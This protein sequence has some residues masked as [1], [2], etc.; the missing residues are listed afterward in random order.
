MVIALFKVKIAILLDPNNSWI[1]PYIKTISLNTDLSDVYHFSFFKNPDLIKGYDLVFILG[2]TNILDKR[3]FDSNKLC[4]AVHES[5]LP[6]GKGFSPVQWQVLEGKKCIP[7]C[8]FE[9]VEAVDSG[10]I[11]GKGY[12]ELDGYELFY[13]IR[14][15]QALVTMDLM[16]E[17][18][19]KYPDIESQKQEGE[20]TFY[21]RRT[22]K[23]DELNINKTIKE[24]F[25]HF[26]IANNDDYPLY[27]VIDGHK[28][29]LNIYKA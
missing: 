2:Y 19:L 15:K 6:F 5:D 4:L 16:I 11:Y 14:E 9:T 23:D 8:L 13:E 28:Y 20:S 27:F 24:Q 22:V 26:R 12:I 3:F 21:P 17:F 18:L 25:N 7:V 1:E 10:N 29:Y